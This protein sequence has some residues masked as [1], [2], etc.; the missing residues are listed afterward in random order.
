MARAVPLARPTLRPLEE[1]FLE[2]DTSTFGLGVRWLKHLCL[3]HEDDQLGPFLEDHGL[4][5][6][7]FWWLLLELIGA[8][9]EKG[10]VPA[11]V[12]SETK[13]A[14]DL[15]TSVRTFRK[16]HDSL[17][18]RGLIQSEIIDE[19]SLNSSKFART[20]QPPPS[21]C[22]TKGRQNYLQSISIR[23][24]ITVPNLLKYRD[25]WQIRSGAT[26]EF[27][28]SH[29]AHR[30]EENRSDT[31]QS[32]T[33]TEQKGFVRLP[34]PP[35]KRPPEASMRFSEFWDKYPLKDG[36][37]MCSQ[38]W[39]SLVT[40]ESEGAVFDCL[41]RYLSS[42]HVARGVVK[43]PNNWLHDCSRDAWK[44]DW[45]RPAPVPNGRPTAS[46]MAEELRKR[47]REK[48]KC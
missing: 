48:L 3:A 34:E 40:V 9:I 14:S 47:D 36:L 38:L 5:G 8:P 18:L 2:Y 20:L 30:A 41:S 43:S 4:E 22:K 17:V 28:P 13:W 33:H 32:R 23:L 11:L 35:K 26:R 37:Q 44:S 7:G 25:E 12:H 27:L 42:D 10:S 16:L 39:L 24:R 29:S 21:G 45:P 19:S 6:Y 15:H 31:E 46:T 1:G